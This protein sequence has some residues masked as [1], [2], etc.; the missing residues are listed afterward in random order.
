LV[1]AKASVGRAAAQT[2]LKK[3]RGHVRRAVALAR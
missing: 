2:A 1:M 3:S